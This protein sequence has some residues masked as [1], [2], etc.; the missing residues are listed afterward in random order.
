VGDRVVVFGE[1]GVILNV[2]CSWSNLEAEVEDGV[3]E[4]GFGEVRKVF[5]DMLVK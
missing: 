5:E 1:R 2:D 3:R 4:L